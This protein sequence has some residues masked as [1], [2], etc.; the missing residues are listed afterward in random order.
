MKG[1]S[2]VNEDFGGRR[3]AFTRPPVLDQST[4]V[5][6]TDAT[7]IW[8][9]VAAEAEQSLP[10]QS[11]GCMPRL[12]TDVQSGLFTLVVSNSW[13]HDA[14]A[15]RQQLSAL[16]TRQHRKPRVS[17][18][19]HGHSPE[20]CSH[21]SHKSRLRDHSASDCA[22]TA[23]CEGGGSSDPFGFHTHQR[24]AVVAVASAQLHLPE[25]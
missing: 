13:V 19:R 10:V 22:T 3:L 25:D 1:T 2:A 24:T 18:S 14:L 7:H 11:L 5:Q 20:T 12:I 6:V 9:R 8:V 15:H 4:L 17:S 21:G 16:Q 23:I